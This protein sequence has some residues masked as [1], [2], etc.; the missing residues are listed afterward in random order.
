MTMSFG[1]QIAVML[2]VLDGVVIP[3]TLVEPILRSILYA[4][5]KVY[6][7][8]MLYANYKVYL[9]FMLYAYYKYKIYLF[10]ALHFTSCYIFSTFPRNYNHLFSTRL[11]AFSL[12][13]FKMNVA[14]NT[15]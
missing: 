13:N 8:F 2:I 4:N 12:N 15:P 3:S 1:S 6:L 11:R 5:Y 9:R 7:R 14:K 10:T